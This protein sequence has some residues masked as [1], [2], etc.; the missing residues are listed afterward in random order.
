MLEQVW[1]GSAGFFEV[2]Y[3]RNSLGLAGLMRS[4]GHFTHI[5]PE[6]YNTKTGGK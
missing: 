3:K 6:V 4:I 5:L 2:L 1:G